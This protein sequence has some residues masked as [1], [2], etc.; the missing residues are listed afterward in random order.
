[1]LNHNTAGSG[2]SS[3]AEP[4][5]IVQSRLKFLGKFR[6]A[7]PPATCQARPLPTRLTLR[8]MAYEN[9]DLRWPLSAR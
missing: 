3:Q 1:M 6:K 9:A 4:F 7:V 2:S 5:G 8:Q